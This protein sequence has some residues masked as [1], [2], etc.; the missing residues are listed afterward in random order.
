MSV[1]WLEFLLEYMDYYKMNRLYTHP[2]G[3]E[4]VKKEFMEFLQTLHGYMDPDELEKILDRAR[5][6]LEQ[7]MLSLKSR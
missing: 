6:G 7:F 1:K 3:G 4:R 2:F 5:K